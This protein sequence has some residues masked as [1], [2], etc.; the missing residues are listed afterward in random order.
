[1]LT[2]IGL[3]GCA[4]ALSLS[5]GG[6]GVPS[7]VSYTYRGGPIPLRVDASRIAVLR[8]AGEIRAEDLT[9]PGAVSRPLGINGWSII[10]LP[11]PTAASEVSGLRAE[12]VA[13]GAFFSP[14]CLDAAGGTTL[15]TPDILVRF[16]PGVTRATAEEALAGVGAAIVAA[17]HAGLVNLYRVKLGTLSGFEVFDTA[18]AL[19]ARADVEFA[20]PDLIVTVRPHE[21]IPND[22]H[23]FRCWHLHSTGQ[24]IIQGY[25]INPPLP[26]TFVVPDFDID[27]PEAWDVATGD[28]SI[29][30]VVFDQGVQLDHPELSI[31]PLL[32]R[33]FTTG[34]PGGIPGGDPVTQCD[35]HGTTVAGVIGADINNDIG[36]VGVAPGTRVA[37]ARIIINTCAGELGE[38]C[39]IIEG[40][41]WAEEIGARIT[42]HSYGIAT[43]SA[44]LD[45]KIE[46]TRLGGMLHFGSAGNVGTEEVSYPARLPGFFA[47]G[48]T[49]PIGGTR[50][51]DSSFG[52]EIDAVA[53]GFAV[54]TTDRTGLDGSDTFTVEDDYVFM[55]GTS[56]SAPTAAGVAA[57]MFSAKPSLS[58]DDAESILRRSCIDMGDL[59]WDE[60][61]G[62]GH[63][64]AHRAV[65]WA[66]CPADLNLDG[67]ADFADYLEFLNMYEAQDFSI[68]F[69]L[70]GFIDFSDYLEFLNYYDAGC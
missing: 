45:A 19:A 59:G 23:F 39:W 22:E 53:P 29:I 17:D 28:S 44:T 54:F 30:T 57:L 16:R 42:N 58:A 14:V 66:V 55:I 35:N 67:F 70:D 8:D 61:H 7:E 62:H 60:L 4:A 68:D 15:V 37:S 9:I 63:I 56:F 5:A 64:N 27:A 40:L 6:N 10:T 49:E 12:L 48:A 2:A 52:A 46:L 1:M 43:P 21:V 47:V 65:R 3:Y 51:I 18:N 38:T 50:W 24:D 13:S 41:V 33:D 11:A 69:N 26:P 36:G 20:E 25:P 31:D 32:G 34:V